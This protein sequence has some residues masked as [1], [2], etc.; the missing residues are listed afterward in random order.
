MR[1]GASADAAYAIN[2]AV[3]QAISAVLR[4]AGTPALAQFE[5]ECLDSPDRIQV[6]IHDQGPPWVGA[7][8]L[9]ARLIPCRRSNWYAPWLMRWNTLPHPSGNRLKLARFRTRPVLDDED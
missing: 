3:V 8:A 9:P 4:Y 5:L 1:P 2:M 7:Q 6:C